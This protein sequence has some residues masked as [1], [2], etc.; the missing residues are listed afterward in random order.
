MGKKNEK[1]ES[2]NNNAYKR[3]KE[4]ATSRYKSKS[5]ADTRISAV[6][7]FVEF[8]NARGIR[9]DEADYST[10]D[11]FLENGLELKLSRTTIQNRYSFLKSFFIYLREQQDN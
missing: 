11:E 6:K 7:K 2:F 10:V 8:L 4:Y 3:Y 5:S 9:V 1:T